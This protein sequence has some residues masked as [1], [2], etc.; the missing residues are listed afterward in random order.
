M[1]DKLYKYHGTIARFSTRGRTM[2][3]VLWNSNDLEK[4][5]VRLEAHG[6]LAEYLWN[7]DMTDV[8]EKYIDADWY[9]DSNLFLRHV[10]IP[11]SD[12]FPAKII[13]QLDCTAKEIVVFGDKEYIDTLKPRSMSR[14]EHHSWCA[15][16][17]N[18]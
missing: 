4:A 16:H 12:R 18:N 1:A 7:R 8:E 3:I 5:P 11:G 10:E 9:Y 6:A 17:A 13:T 15:W 14:E 2:D